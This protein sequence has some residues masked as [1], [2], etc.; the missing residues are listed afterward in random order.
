MSYIDSQSYQGIGAQL[1][2]GSVVGGSGSNFTAVFELTDQ[3]LPEG[4]WD[5]LNVSNFNS[6]GK[7]KEYRK[8]MVDYGEIKLKG[9][10]IPGDP[11]Q[12]AMAAA[13]ADP[14]NPYQ[15]KLQMPVAPGQAT[16][17]VLFAFSAMVMGWSEASTLQPDKT[18]E[19]TATLQITGPLNRT[20]GS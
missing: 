12:L 7:A 8:G 18:V 14:S 1:S 19:C 4:N 10:S 3:A 2:I 9:N 17:G 6:V 16:E 11:G 20:A 15:F 5:K 13:F